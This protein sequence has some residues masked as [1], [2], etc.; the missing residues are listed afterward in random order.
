MK[1]ARI[2]NAKTGA[3]LSHFDFEDMSVNE[4]NEILSALSAWN[5]LDGIEKHRKKDD[6]PA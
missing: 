1:L 2:Y 4:F 5:V 6:K 3:Q